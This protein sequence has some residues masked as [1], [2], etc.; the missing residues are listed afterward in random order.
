M[1]QAGEATVDWNIWSGGALEQRGVC[2]LG[3]GERPA[4]G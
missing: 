3:G 4:R 1:V 2:H